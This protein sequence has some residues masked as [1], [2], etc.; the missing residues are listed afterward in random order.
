MTRR[1]TC[2]LALG[3]FLLTAPAMA[4]SNLSPGLVLSCEACHG[5]YGDSQRPDVP[6]LNGQSRDYLLI[7][8]R[9]FRDPTRNTPHATLMMWQNSTSVTDTQ[10]AALADYFSSQAPTSRGGFGP[11]AAR[12]NELFHHGAG[13]DT[14]ACATCHGQDGEGLGSAPRVAGQHETYLNRQLEA[15][16]LTARVGDPMNHHTWAMS[17]EEIRAVAAYL[18]NN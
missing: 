6:R 9:E 15:F 3:A 2:L 12:G 10:A 11:D 14:A 17:A 5:K 7:R 8:M 1:I 16:Q 13:P 18:A 4:Q